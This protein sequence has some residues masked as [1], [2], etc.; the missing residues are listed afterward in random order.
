ML[1]CPNQKQI[2]MPFDFIYIKFPCTF[3][4]IYDSAFQLLFYSLAKIDASAF[5]QCHFPPPFWI[6]ISKDKFFFFAEFVEP[7]SCYQI[8]MTDQ[9]LWRYPIKDDRPDLEYYQLRLSI[10]KNW[11]LN[12]KVLLSSAVG[13]DR[14]PSP[15]SLCMH[16]LAH[17]PSLKVLLNTTWKVKC[18]KEVKLSVT[19]RLVIFKVQLI[20]L[21][22]K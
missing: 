9:V 10:T 19:R 13:S 2:S 8:N 20:I 5:V 7:N 14:S 21:Q 16:W 6:K 1:L 4:K 12:L 15:C 11:V 17:W 18:C 22:S 3:T